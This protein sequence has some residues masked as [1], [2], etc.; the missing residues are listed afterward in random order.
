ML[1]TYTHLFDFHAIPLN[2]NQLYDFSLLMEIVIRKGKSCL[3]ALQIRTKNVRINGRESV[4][5]QS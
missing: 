5:R 3:L 2:N 4:L 1:F